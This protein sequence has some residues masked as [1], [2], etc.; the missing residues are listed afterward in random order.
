MK[1]VVRNKVQPMKKNE[2]MAAYIAG[3]I[4][5][6]LRYARKAGILDILQKILAALSLP[7]SIYCTRR[8][9][10][11]VVSIITGGGASMASLAPWLAGLFSAI[12]VQEGGV[13]FDS[14]INIMLK[15]E[16]N[17]HFTGVIAEKFK[18][19]EYRY[20]ED[21]G[22]HDV[23]SRMGSEPQ[24]KILEIYR[25]GLESVSRTAAIIGTSLIL[26]N[27]SPFFSAVFFLFVIVQILFSAKAAKDMNTMFSNQSPAERDLGYLSGLLEHKDSIFELRLFGAV[28]Y[29]LN[30]WKAINKQVLNERITATVRAERYLAAGFLLIIAW[31][32]FVFVYLVNRLAARSLSIDVFIALIISLNTIL[33]LSDRLSYSFSEAARKFPFMKYFREFM[34]FTDEEPDAGPAVK[35]GRLRFPE[36][37][38]R[39]VSF[40][41]PGTEREILR[42]LSFVIK[43]GR[44]VALV[45]ENGAGKSTI[46]KLLLRLYRPDRG[47]IL[48][49]GIDLNTLSR[50]E[51]G[52][53]FSVEFQDYAVYSLTLRENTAFGNI[54]KINDDGEI[55]KA[56]DRGMASELASL[57]PKGLD[58]PIGKIEDDGI[59]L[60][61]GQKQ[62][63]ALSRA[64]L[65]DGAFIILDEPTAA[66]DPRAESR[67][68]ETFA[69][70]LKIAV[71]S[72]YPTGWPARVWR[73]RL[74]LS[75]KAAC[76]KAEPTGNLW[77]KRDY[78][79]KC[80]R[81]RRN[82]TR[83]PRV[84]RAIYENGAAF[85]PGVLCNGSNRAG[86]GSGGVHRVAG[87]GAYAC[88]TGKT[89]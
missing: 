11:T 58:V 16:L 18:K 40:K 52:A 31:T 84:R 74:S 56:L 78:T 10:Q 86:F 67:L 35:D 6:V 75:D 25:Y 24:Y 34:N 88:R 70:I 47:V 57:H 49:N 13:Y 41:Y 69:H 29:I 2:G 9:I 71:P 61:G 33:N 20:F 26:V 80:I 63:L 66:L 39:Q 62:R 83:T 14:V 53:L 19:I 4:T 30:K 55:R 43:N 50:E 27:I 60:S 79:P 5:L 51:I 36:I 44:R 89:P 28:D 7:V 68:Y 32:V 12:L 17:R 73:I 82:G 64:A 46:I 42:G 54:A 8:V 23:L 22:A 65:G 48:I 72:W 37:E 38:F 15:R 45:G 77:R 76:W 59:D 85:C 87:P 81:N 3:S 1:A 21:S